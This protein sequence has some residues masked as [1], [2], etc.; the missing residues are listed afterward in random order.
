LDF[1]AHRVAGNGPAERHRDPAATDPVRFAEQWSSIGTGRQRRR[2]QILGCER[3]R[4][5]RHAEK[6]PPFVQCCL[7]SGME[8]MA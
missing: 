1:A 3:R 4:F 6:S 7:F 2:A 5:R 8:G